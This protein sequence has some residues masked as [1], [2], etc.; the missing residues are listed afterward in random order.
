MSDEEQAGEPELELSD[1]EVGEPV[2]HIEAHDAAHV[3]ESQE[4]EVD[5]SDLRTYDVPDPPEPPMTCLRL[6]LAVPIGLVL[7]VG[8]LQ[9]TQASHYFAVATNP[10]EYSG[11]R[12]TARDMINE[13]PSGEIKERVLAITDPAA[14]GGF[15]SVLAETKD[16][17]QV[18]AIVAFVAA[19]RGYRDEQVTKAFESLRAFPSEVAGPALVE[20]AEAHTESSGIEIGKLARRELQEHYPPE[21][22]LKAVLAVEDA[23]KRGAYFWV[24]PASKDPNQ[25]DAILAYVKTQGTRSEDSSSFYG[26]EEPTDFKAEAA[27]L[28][29]FG[30]PATPKLKK[31]LH[32][33]EGSIVNLAAEA[34][35]QVNLEF[36]HGYC[37]EELGTYAKNI[38]GPK[39]VGWASSVVSMSERA[40]GLAG[41]KLT[42]SDVLVAKKVL[43]GAARHSGR[44]MEML[45]AMETLK[46]EEIDYCFIHGLSCYDMEVA[47]YC[48]T[49]LQRR[50]KTEE[51]IDVL[52]S[53]IAQKDSFSKKEVEVYESLLIR[54]GPSGAVRVAWNLER[55][56]KVAKGETEEVFFLY[57]KMAFQTLNK[58]GTKAQI[59]TLERFAEDTGSYLKTGR[60]RSGERT[61]TEVKFKDEVRAAIK[62]IQGRGR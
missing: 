5:V 14:R 28:M 48:A 45:K 10:G 23:P 47:N 33:P 24:L 4:P 26:S 54:T 34:L 2:S 13:L 1:I 6:F 42:A 30:K 12:E 43:G 56:F 58:N 9:S 35:A 39:G 22:C 19:Y 25:I 32:S 8:L 20:L 53:F 16:P 60:S 21:S 29:A 46:G 3:K 52:F 57:K 7:A 27:A 59:S 17:A 15:H 62:A 40:G 41:N 36:L 50:L 38:Y 61:E 55:L 44:I 11:N 37:R 51:L 49:L 18:E 31:A